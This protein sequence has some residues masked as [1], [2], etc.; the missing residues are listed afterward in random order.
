[1]SFGRVVECG[2]AKCAQKAE[3]GEEGHGS[4]VSINKNAC[5]CCVVL[6][7]AIHRPQFQSSRPPLSTTPY[8]S[9]TPCVSLASRVTVSRRALGRSRARVCGLKQVINRAACK[10]RESAGSRGGSEGGLAQHLALHRCDHH[11]LGGAL[12]DL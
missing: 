9:G 8:Q 11:L 3:E 12:W 4:P 2:R 6:E 7:A 10:T 5:C 1:M